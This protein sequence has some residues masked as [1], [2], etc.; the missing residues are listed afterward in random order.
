[1]IGTAAWWWDTLINRGG[2]H[3]KAGAR[4]SRF[5]M[6]ARYERSIDLYMGDVKAA[7][8]FGRQT[9]QVVYLGR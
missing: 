8:E 9:L 6:N 5:E 3:T 1:M 4:C 2:V 7:K